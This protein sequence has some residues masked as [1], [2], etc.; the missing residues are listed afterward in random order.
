MPAIS[1]DD[2][3]APDV[4][5]LLERHLA[6][7]RATTRPEDVHAMEVEALAEP[8]V[9]FFSYR[10]GGRVLG[11]GALKDLSAD[12]AEI[13]SMH[14]AEEAR[15]RGVARE[16]LAHLVGVAR[17]RGFRRL[18]LETGAQDA[19]APARALYASAGFEFCEAFGPYSPSPNSAYMTLPLERNLLMARRIAATPVRY[20]F[21]FV[22]AGDSG[23]WPDPTADAIVSSLIA[24]TGRLDPAPVFFA[25]L[26]DFAGPGTVERHEDWLRLVEPLRVPNVCAVGNHDLDDPRGREAWA[27]VHGP[28]NYEFGH[29]HTRFV[30]LDAAPGAVGEV[31]IDPATVSGPDAEALAFLDAAL[32]RASEPHRVVLMHAPPALGGRFEPHPEWGFTVLEREFLA[33][34]ER[35]RVALVC[36]AHALF[37]DTFVHRGTRFVVSGGGG[38]AL[39]SHYHGVCAAGEGRPEDR[40][41]LFHAVQIVVDEAGAVSG[42]VLQAFEPDA[43]RARIT[44]GA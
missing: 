10:D 31:D 3:L 6:Y 20:P 4:R 28:H 8:G 43:G 21:S 37:F 32:S 40:G 14:T 24:Q 18:S 35:H 7:A 30:V 13:K 36:C 15:G 39:C 22:F 26:G 44:F 1:P 16:L 25:N 27:A 12:H 34:V 41:A 29:G 23:A 19:F 33:L 11:V 42:R 17:T 5:A 38:T 9:T 2:P